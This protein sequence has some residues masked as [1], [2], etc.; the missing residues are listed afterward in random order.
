KYDEVVFCGYG[1]PTERLEQLIAACRYIRSVSD[2][3]IR[4]NTN[5]LAS[6]SHG[7]D[8]PPLLEGL[9][10]T[11]SVSM[12]AP[13]EEEYLQVTQPCFG[14]GAFDAMLSFVRA[15]KG[16]FPK[17]MVTAVDVITDEQAARCQALA[18]EIGVP[19]RLRTFS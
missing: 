6:L 13:T 10:D 19:F 18:D 4:I 11:V 16:R 2:I 7:K 14:K 9:I 12:N 3:P 8:V 1:E 5:G 15:C 17:V